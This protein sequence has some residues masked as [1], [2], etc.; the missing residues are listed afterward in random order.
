MRRLRRH[1]SAL[2]VATALAL[3]V[4]VA[5]LLGGG[6]RTTDPL[7][8]DNPDPDGAQAVARVL[9]DRGV[10][11]EV[12]RDAAALDAV[13]VDAGTTVVVTGTEALGRSTAEG[14]LRAAAPGRLVVVD[15][16]PGALDALGLAAEPVAVD[17]GDGLAAG[18][19]TPALAGLVLATDTATAYDAPGCF[20]S[21]GRA[22]VAE[23]GGVTLLGAGQAL[24]NDQVLR[25]DN[26][27]VALRL[28][29]QGQRLVW[30]VPS[31]GDLEGGD[32]VGLSGLV[33][34]WVAPGLVLAVVV[35]LAVV[36]WRGRRLGRLS[37]EPLPVAVSAVETTLSRGRLYHH[38]SDRGHAARALRE[39]ARRRGAA[40]LRLPV[41]AGLDVVAEQ[42]AARTGRSAADVA[43]LL[44]P[45]S[46]APGTDRD[47][48]ALA[49][50]LAELDREVRTP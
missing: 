11:V 40:R 14:L 18:C 47:L 49:G 5:V 35:L 31:V 7:D 34:R 3:A 32:A 26:A 20:G 29:G 36:L 25:A 43:R 16:R 6:A 13:D 37:V 4:V 2:V 1:T 28:L 48:I 41:G 39:A 50:A 33:P 21:R 19:G 23:V 22:V 15:A 24:S 8:P 9:S 44:D 38:A 45:D 27:A 12:A 46:P 10:Q 30:Y 17:P 42:V